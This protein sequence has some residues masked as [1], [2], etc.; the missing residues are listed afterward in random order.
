MLATTD[1]YDWRGVLVLLLA[2]FVLL[3]FRGGGRKPPRLTI[4]AT[5]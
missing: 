1:W 3:G 2:L 5:R 4:G